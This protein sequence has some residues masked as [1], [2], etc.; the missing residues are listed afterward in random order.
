MSV[1]CKTLASSV[2]LLLLAT[3]TR[4]ATLDPRWCGVDRTTASRSS[5][6]EAST[7]A[8]DPLVEARIVFVG[9]PN[10]FQQLPTWG[11]AL[12]AELADYIAA[13]S[14]GR[15]RFNL[16]IL[17][18]PDAPGDAWLAAHPPSYYEDPLRGYAAVNVE[19]MT[20]IDSMIPNAWNGVEQVFMIHYRCAWSPSECGAVGWSGLGFIAAGTVPG[21]TGRGTTQRIVGPTVN[22]A[23]EASTAAHLA[24]H[25]YGH[26]LGFLH[27]PG[28][29]PQLTFPS[30]IVNMGRYDA[31]TAT[32]SYVR[33]DGLVPYHAMWLS[34][35][36][37]GWLPREIITADTLGL[38]VPDVR[39]PNAVAYLVPTSDPTQSF[40]LV[41]H[42][43]T[44]PW[45]LKY[46]NRGLLI[47]HL[48]TSPN[49]RAWDLESADGKYAV[50]NGQLDRTRPD[51]VAGLDALEASSS[52]LGSGADFFDGAGAADGH[53]DDRLS[54]T[55]NPQTYLYSGIPPL[56]S[57]PQSRPTSITFENIR[58]DASTGDMLVD[59]RGIPPPAPIAAPEVLQ[60]SPNPFARATSIRFVLFEPSPVKIE[61]FDLQG[62][63]LRVLQDGVL[64]AGS[65]LVGWDGA[66]ASGQAVP[67][68]VY[69]Y[70]VT[71]GA[72][73]AQKKMVLLGSGGPSFKPQ[74]SRGAPARR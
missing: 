18:R 56:Y 20:R 40:L 23:L 46:G 72:F 8:A 63:R 60:N 13:M 51:P 1:V 47:W 3:S 42:Q 22:T 50:T 27:S 38:R 5:P 28:T 43:G 17:T 62:R 57:L 64:G 71:A 14:R 32:A 69:F 45:D 29:S 26:G 2:V 11:E 25:E 44:T 41:N 39:G 61:V 37:L 24:G 19:V 6:S 7:L 74:P 34:D 65:H 54:P 68:A 55:S 35:P 58:R 52:W 15:Q 59:I 21:F 53:D 36:A 33:Q 67:G 10:D 73:R 48:L 30:E 16:S 12:R 66:D 49:P 4:S 31:M 9:F 70:R